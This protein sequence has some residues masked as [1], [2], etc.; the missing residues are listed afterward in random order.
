MDALNTLVLRAQLAEEHCELHHGPHTHHEKRPA[1]DYLVQPFGKVVNEIEEVV[2]REI[3]VPICR[4]CVSA[5]QGEEWTLLY[6]FECG[7]SRWV[8]RQLAKNRYRHSILWLRGCPDCSKAFAG[9]Y[10]TDFKAAANNFALFSPQTIP[11]AL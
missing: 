11:L 2:A 4:D 5:L 1:V 7:G 3:V 6:C 9:L 8:Y 10:F